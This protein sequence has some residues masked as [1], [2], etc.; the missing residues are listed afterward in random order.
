M[1]EQVGEVERVGWQTV[2]PGGDGGADGGGVVKLNGMGDTAG[3]DD[4]AVIDS[5]SIGSVV[6][7]IEQSVCIAVRGRGS[8]SGISHA[9]SPR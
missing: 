4:V 3:M 5:D 6:W 9:A 8:V 1:A 7:T 2:G